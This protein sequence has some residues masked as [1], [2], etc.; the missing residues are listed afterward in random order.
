MVV[1]EGH[2]DHLEEEFF[3]LQRLG[4]RQRRRDDLDV[5]FL[6]GAVEVLQRRNPV[7]PVPLR[8]L[9][10]DDVDAELLALLGVGDEGLR[11]IDAVA[12]EKLELLGEPIWR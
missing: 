10:F 2:V 7:G 12:D 5:L 1:G 6:H 4:A 3:L 9:Q 8:D 11:R